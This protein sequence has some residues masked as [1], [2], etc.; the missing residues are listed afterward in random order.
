M[1]PIF[2][3]LA[4]LATGCST[5]S[6]S[7]DRFVVHEWGTFTSMQGAP[8]EILEGLQHESEPL[9]G[10]VHSRI[11]SKPS[12]FARFGDH[13]RNVRAVRH[14]TGKMETPVIYFYDGRARHVS[15]HVDF[16]AGL[17]TQ[18]YPRAAKMAPRADATSAEIDLGRLASSSLDWELDLVPHSQPAPAAMPA[19]SGAEPWGLARNV[20]ADWVVANGEADHYVFYRG[21]GRMDV[22]L[23]VEARDDGAAIR[24]ATVDAIPAAFVVEMHAHTARFLTLASIAPAESANADL[25][26]EPLLPAAVVVARLEHAMQTALE[27][28]G[29]Y[30][31]EASAMVRTWSSTWFGQEGRRVLYLVPRAQTDAT[32]PL[33]ITPVPDQT[34]RVLVGRLEYLAPAER[35][36][37]ERTLA[38]RDARDP[39]LRAAATTRLAK[40]G[41]F[42]EP[43]ARA[44]LTSSSDPRVRENAMA[45]L[46]EF[47]QAK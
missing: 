28:Q 27:A 44:V 2:A 19:V 33:Q 46:D 38:D 37:I 29:L 43:A 1:R 42:L 12:P 36:E 14:C 22:P 16:T 24:N 47:A 11:G 40:L 34:V 9:P 35:A 7:P 6:A 3:A 25:S 17:L 39:A 23:A 41:R 26:G 20:D 45:V 32:I 4:L 21:L 10:F 30:E 13:S 8:G 31:K 18:W 5:A 15:V